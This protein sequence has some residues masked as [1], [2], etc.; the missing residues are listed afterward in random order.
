MVDRLT[1][2]VLQDFPASVVPGMIDFP[3]FLFLVFFY[4]ILAPWP[5]ETARMIQAR[6]L[7]GTDL[8]LDDHVAGP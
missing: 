5:V 2:H 7:P 1:G 8:D 3:D 6:F 4:R